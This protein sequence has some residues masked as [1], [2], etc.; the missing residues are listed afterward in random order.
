MSVIYQH[1]RPE[2]K[3]FIDQVTS[4]Q[5]YVENTYSEKLTD[6]LNPR[7]QYI[8][9]SIIG[10]NNEIKYIFFGGTENCERKRALIFPE[11]LQP[12]NEDFQITLYEI[13]YPKKFLNLDHRM[14]LG[15]LMSIGLKREKYGDIIIN[16][17]R[18]QF[19]LATEVEQFVTIQLNQIGKA[20]VSV[21][22]LDLK[23][24][25]ISDE[26]WKEKETTASSLRLDVILAAAFNISRQKA[27][28][29]IQQGHAKVN[30]ETVERTAFECD[31]GDVLSARGHGRCCLLS[32]QGKTKKDKLRIK[33]GLLK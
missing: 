13:E 6:F 16:G 24:A 30:W 33:L 32:I 14:V 17:D 7:E 2:E 19:F 1:F 28:L 9:R 29:L 10:E 21:S 3:E 22:K 27:Q 20:K 8:L 11:Y 26:D 25:I 15:S 12:S 18:I 31:E 5:Q 4:W 23:N